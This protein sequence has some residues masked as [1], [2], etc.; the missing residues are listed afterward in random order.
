MEKQIFII[1]ICFIWNTVSA[2]QN[3]YLDALK[4]KEIYDEDKAKNIEYFQLNNEINSVLSPYK[5]KLDEL[6]SNPFLTNEYFPKEKQYSNPKVNGG[7]M[8]LDSF[9]L[10]NIT[11]SKASAINQPNWQTLIIK[12]TSDFLAD[13]FTAELISMATNKSFQK[14]KDLQTVKSLF[15][16]SIQLINEISDENA[17]TSTYALDFNILKSMVKRD[18]EEMPKNIPSLTGLNPTQKDFYNIGYQIAIQTK[19][20]FSIQ[21]IIENLSNSNEV[22]N[23]DLQLALKRLNILLHE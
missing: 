7:N 12:G 21:Q 16:K 2:Q 10:L 6:N 23:Q 15:P 8:I 11:D 9:Q 22:I 14:I 17:E 13:R 18:I 20:G 1:M 19:E 3:T 5:L 4:L